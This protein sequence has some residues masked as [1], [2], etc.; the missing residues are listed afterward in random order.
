MP[1]LVNTPH[2]RTVRLTLTAKHTVPELGRYRGVISLFQ[3]L[4]KDRH[5]LNADGHANP[6]DY[7]EEMNDAVQ[8]MLDRDAGFTESEIYDAGFEEAA[9]AGDA[10]GEAM[11][12]EQIWDKIQEIGQ[13]LGM[14]PEEDDDDD[15]YVF[16]TLGSM[17]RLADENGNE[18]IEIS[19]AEEES[20]DNT[21]TVI[22]YDPSKPGCAAIYHTGGVMSTLICEKGKRHI[23]AY[24]TPIMPF[25]VAVFTK[26]C[27]GGF[28]FENGG[29]LE[30]DYMVE[31]R[32]ADMQRTMM[33]IDVRVL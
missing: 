17:E 8:D 21:G 15:L 13:K 14:Q 30:L 3:E 10:E 5:P 29:S 20:M 1:E 31:I 23:S 22:R 19:Y 2:R 12:L 4:K 25:E 9:E 26:K 27:E 24:Q 16:R 32:G 7:P 6:E 33:T 18:V 11:T 28:T